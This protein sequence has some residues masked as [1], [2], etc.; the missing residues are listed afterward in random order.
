MCNFSL[1]T[2]NLHIFSNKVL[3]FLFHAIFFV[4]FSLKKLNV[5]LLS[6]NTIAT[7]TTLVIM[8]EVR[9]FTTREE[10]RKRKSAH[11]IFIPEQVGQDLRDFGIELDTELPTLEN[12][13]KDDDSGCEPK[14]K[15]VT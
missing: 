9:T 5:V 6:I 15:R 1:Q 13:V 7:A 3:H 12:I 8:T 4:L 10:G 11:H 14:R 2:C